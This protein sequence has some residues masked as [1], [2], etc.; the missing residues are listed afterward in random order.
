MGPKGFHGR[1]YAVTEAPRVLTSGRVEVRDSETRSDESKGL[2]GTEV[3][4][5]ASFNP[6]P[7]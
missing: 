6:K 3:Y 2:K 1:K 5:E 4:G 7:S